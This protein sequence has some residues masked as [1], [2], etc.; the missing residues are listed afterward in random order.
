MDRWLITFFIGSILSLF[1]PIVPEFFYV[2]FFILTGLVCLLNK[3]TRMVSGLFLGAAWILFNGV[4]YQQVWSSNNLDIQQLSN[5]AHFLKGNITSIPVKKNIK[6]KTQNNP[7]LSYKPSDKFN[8]K[9]NFM[10]S[11]VDDKRLISPFVIRLNWNYALADLNQGEQWNLKA[12]FKPPHGFTNKGGFNY[13]VWLRQ[14]VIVATGYVVKN[15]ENSR[16]NADITQRQSLYNNAL[17]LLPKHELSDLL[18]ALSFGEKS[19]ISQDVWHVLQKTNTQHLIAISGLHLGLI[20]TGS[21]LLI[22]FLIKILPITNVVRAVS[23]TYNVHHFLSVNSKLVV[24]FL[25]CSLTFYYA[26]LAGFSLPTVRALIMLFLFWFSRLIGIKLS[27]LRWFFLTLFIVLIVSPFSL[28]SGS[29]WLSFY[30]VSLILLTMWRF[31]SSFTGIN[32]G[33]RWLKSLLYIQLSLSI[34][35]LPISM[36]FNYQLS[37]VSIF[38][39]LVAVP[40]MSFTSIP[41]C[42]LAVLVMPFSEVFSTYLYELALLSTQYLW[43]WLEFLSDQPWALME[44]SFHHILVI[45]SVLS[46][47][48]LICFLSVKWK[49]ISFVIFISMAY[50]INYFLFSTQH[51]PWKVV[52]LDVGQGLSVVIEKGQHAILYDTGASYPSGFN[53]IEAAVLPYLKHQGIKMLDKVIISHSDNDHAGGLGVLQKNIKIDELIANDPKLKGYNKC[54]Q[55][56]EFT[57]QGLTF[58]ILWPPKEAQYKGDENDHSCVIRVSDANNSV[59]LTGDISAKVEKLLVSTNSIVSMLN[60]DVVIAPHHGS[61]TSSST[62]FIQSISPEY[63]IYSTGFMNRWNMPS[64]LVQKRYTENNV[65]AYNTAESGMIEI[66]VQLDKRSESPNNAIHK[67]ITVIPYKQEMFPFWFAH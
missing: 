48:G 5:N 14:N 27:L 4:Q 60:S 52:V 31:T 16:L 28:M 36:L 58:S 20:A 9:F 15:K 33:V 67:M 38:A 34:L 32:R 55:G 25:S 23:K 43:F 42:L 1:I 46:V 65:K 11:H 7:L 2:N 39:N 6:H 61:K 50:G 59:L 40:V 13:Q 30:A 37:L 41:L 64:N 18:T 47:I 53:M 66:N 22:G 44:V 56:N 19:R 45:S 21:F 3:K 29:F 24:V 63:V 17:E 12:K 49:T 10:V 57:W 62:T 51:E 35:M 54:E 26:Y 8:Y